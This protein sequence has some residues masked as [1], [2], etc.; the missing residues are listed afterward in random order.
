[1]DM[2]DAGLLSDLA[3]NALLNE[4]DRSLGELNGMPLPPEFAGLVSNAGLDRD[5]Y[6]QSIAAQLGSAAERVQAALDEVLAGPPAQLR[7]RADL[8]RHAEWVGV[9]PADDQATIRA[10]RQGWRDMVIN[11]SQRALL[12]IESTNGPV[13]PPDWQR[14]LGLK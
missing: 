1:M 4:M 13:P 3:A 5:H 11:L 10:W 6:A 12:L 7:S 2:T 14:T 9:D 8:T